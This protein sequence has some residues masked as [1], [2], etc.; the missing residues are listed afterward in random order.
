M[1][2]RADE[3]IRSITNPKVKSWAQLLT[4][5][6]RKESGKF[7]V[8][9][10]HLIEEAF[11]S[12][13]DIEIIA[14]DEEKQLPLDLS[15]LCTGSSA[16]LVPVSR[17]VLEKCSDT[18]TPQGIFAVVRKPKYNVEECLSVPMP[19]GIIADRLQDP[20][21]LGTL[22]RSADAAGASYV[23]VGKNSVDIYSP[24]TIRSTM[25]S[26]FHLPVLEMDLSE[27]FR[28][29]RAQ[30]IAIYG[31]TLQASEHCYE[32]DFTKPTWF[33]IGNEATGIST[34]LREQLTKEML[35]PMKGSSESLNAAMASTIV[36][37][38]AMRQRAFMSPSCI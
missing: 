10:V 27:L 38:E 29:G 14:Y 25:G 6:G 36:L 2:R 19:L 15:E 23:I 21:N 26:I 31:L 17:Q 32:Q 7:I 4:K 16:T 8:E 13:F 35:I 34:E 11:K 5:K 9:G 28:Y 20:G 30:K 18:V 1:V 37:F 12:G 3:V 22:I 24:K 33:V